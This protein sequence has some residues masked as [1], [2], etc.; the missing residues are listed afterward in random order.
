LTR[1]DPFREP[2]QVGTRGD[3]QCGLEC[4]ALPLVPV[5]AGVE[6]ECDPG[7]FGQQVGAA[8]GNL[9][10]LGNRDLSRSSGLRLT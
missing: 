9:S 4:L 1:G 5:F 3:E 7:P 10:Q 8:V 2:R 6:A